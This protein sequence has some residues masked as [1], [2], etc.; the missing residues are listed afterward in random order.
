MAT[1]PENPRPSYKTALGYS[2]DNIKRYRAGDGE[3]ITVVHGI[4]RRKYQLIYKRITIAAR[5]TFMA[6]YEANRDI[7]FD[8]KDFE[9]GTTYTARFT[10]SPATTFQGP[11]S[12]TFSVPIEVDKP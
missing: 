6:F 2:E 11:G 9:T 8:W 10:G 12:C 1:Y 4:L 5:N 3:Q 7:D